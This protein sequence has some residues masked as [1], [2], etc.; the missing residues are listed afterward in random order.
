VGA[1]YLLASLYEHGDGVVMDLAQAVRWYMLA[2]QQGDVAALYKAKALAKKL[3]Y[4][5]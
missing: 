2:A 3:G 5:Y 4:E 1:Q